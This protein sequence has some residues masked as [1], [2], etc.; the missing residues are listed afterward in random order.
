MR[1]TQKKQVEELV[2]QME[3][4]HDQIKK[5]I[6]KK[7]VLQAMGLLE[8]CQNGGISIGTLI[9]NTE[10][11]GHPTVAL[12]EEYC[13]LTYQIHEDLANEKELNANKTHKL[14]KQ[15]LIKIFNSIRSDI[16]IR[17]E[18]VFLPYKASMWDSLES[19]WQ[20]ADADP[21]CNAYVIPI[22]Y[23][24]K[25]PDGGFREM[26]Y[27][28]D[29]YPDYVPVTKF[30]EF[31]F[32]AHRPDMIFIHNPYNNINYVTSVHP[33]FYSD[34]L[35]EFTDCL[36]YIPY[37]T[38]TGGMSEGQSLCPA[39]SNADYIVIQSE[40]HRYFFDERIPNEKFLAFGSPKFDRV[41]R[42]CQNPPKPPKEWEEKIK[43]RTVYFYNTSI[44]GMLANTDA[45]LKKMRYVFDVFKKRDDACLLWRPHPL[46]A[47][48]FDSMRRGYKPLYDTLKKEFVENGTGILDETPDV[49]N[50]IALSDVYIG[51]SATSVTSL[52]GVAGKPLFILNN[53]IHS[54]PEEDD[55]RGEKIQ[56]IFNIWGS[57]KYQVTRNNQ[58]WISDHNDYHYRFYMDLESGYSGGGYYLGAAEIKDKIY[59]FPSNA[60]HLLIIEDK[61]L[62]KIE[63]KENITNAGAFSYY[64]Y[65]EKYI[66]L[67]PFR[68]PYLVRFDI[69][70]E[71]VLYMSGIRQFNV[72]NI[73]GEWLIGGVA[74]Y[75]NELVFASPEDNEFIFVDMDTLK[76]RRLSSNTRCSQGTL[77]IVPHGDELW[78]LPMKG[79]TITCWN[80]KTGSVREYGDVPK[81]F[82]SIKWPQEFECDERP[83]GDIV[84]LRKNDKENIVISPY[85]G[86]IFLALD[87]ETGKTEEWKP[88]IAFT[89]RGKNGYF[90]AGGIGSFIKS[91]L[92][93]SKSDCRIWYSPERKIYSI[94]IDTKEYEEEELDFDYGDLKEHEPGF[95]EDSEWMQYCLNEGVFN[96]LENLLDHN[97]TGNPFDKKRQLKAFSKINAN[98]D[99]T[100]G[101]NVYNFVKGKI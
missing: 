53:Y 71:G 62:R 80:P 21:D 36:V 29:Q 77:K 4:A 23:F 90:L 70:T 92:Q 45:F 100:C 58:L 60:R 17:T 65:N 11:E 41:I 98:T 85:W 43:G 26:H 13:E 38:T 69:E 79:M 15:M 9:E 35:K 99:G 93:Y 101:I 76:A 73:S 28:A 75:G 7:N 52:F 55:W 91:N 72:R 14:L 40:K 1:K 74:P 30:N 64:F 18:A 50:A 61:K 49:E 3:Q 66:F 78:L 42:K 46:L 16:R 37:Y 68:Y 20:A 63:L 32:E 87:R 95:M 89:N 25:N 24:D 94:N 88:P 96:S 27:E 67:F 6:D 51:D 8:D 10:G 12:L 82:K 31:D 19:V 44:N 97:I 22:P 84:F 33:V 86:N 34:K 54:L 57:D 59:V 83:F 5:Y 2:R 56:P 47:S 81:K 39:Y 48:T